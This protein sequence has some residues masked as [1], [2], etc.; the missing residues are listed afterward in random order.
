[1]NAGFDKFSYLNSTFALTFPTV[2]DITS[3]LKCVGR[4]ASLY[5]VDVSRAF[6]HVK[7]DP[8]IMIC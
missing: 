2:D 8:G 5:K 4:G 7:V 6:C 3:E 1:M